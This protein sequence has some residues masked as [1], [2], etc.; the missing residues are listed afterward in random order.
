MPK[1]RVG[2]VNFL[3]S[4]PLAWGFLKGHHA[5]LFA[6]SYHP[7]ALIARLLS[8]GNLDIGL[9]PSIEVQRIPGLK[10]LPDLCIAARHEVRSVILISRCPPEEIRRVALDQN[11]RSS[12][13]LLR[14]L[15]R[16]RFRL[17]PEY[18]HERPDAERMLAEADAALLIGDSALKVDRERY[19]VVDLAAEWYALT[20]LPFVFAV[21][22]V[23]PDVDL[24][25]LPFYFKSSL[26]YGLSSLDNLVRESAAE[27]GL[28]SD[29]VRAYLTEYLHFFLRRDEIAGLEEFY[30]RAHQHGLI[31]EPRPL[32]FW[33]E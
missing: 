9:I 21:W 28:D 1:L 13:A 18:L 30:R 26:R 17:D 27:L 33:G 5:D 25:E 11:S 24:P 20:G 12:A 3:N 4:K 14:I 10:V 15:L 6:P 19:L 7:P 22:A 23:R 8:Q 32:D 16:E 31:L 2:I 29:E